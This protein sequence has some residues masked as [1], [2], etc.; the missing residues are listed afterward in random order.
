M[1][2]S[3]NA[4]RRRFRLPA[5][6]ATMLLCGMGI[7]AAHAA[8][9]TRQIPSAGVTTLNSAA[10]G[11]D[12]GLQF[13]EFQ[14]GL[15]NLNM[16]D[17]PT[18][19][20]NS[21]QLN[22][23]GG[24]QA[25]LQGGRAT[26]RSFARGQG[27]GEWVQGFEQ[28]REH[29]SLAL[30]FDGLNFRQ[31]RLAS[32]GN[33]F[34]VEPPDQ[35]LCVGNGFV[36]ETV[37]DV[38]RVFDTSGN[39][40]T[41]PIALNAFY[42]YAPAIDRT[43]HVFGPSIT[44]PSCYFD[45]QTQRWFHIVVTLDT[46]PASGGLLGSNHI[47]L[48]VSATPSPLGPWNIYRIPV[49]DDGTQ[50]TPVHA[51]CPCLGDYPH[52]GADA[53]GIY[54]TTNEF[55]LFVNGF[56]SAQ[57]YAISKKHLAQGAVSI[58]VVQIDTIDFLLEGNPGFTVWPAA[59]SAGEFEHDNRGTEYFV[60]SLA[61]FSNSNTDN[62]LRL[63]ALTNT[64]SLDSGS[65]NL[66]LANNTM[67][68]AS[69]GVPPPANQKP[70]STPLV[71]CINDT[72]LP[73]P[74]GPGCWHFLFANEP[75]HHE[76]MSPLDSN[77]SRIQQVVFADGKLY[78]ALDTVVTVAGN[79]QAGI[80]FYIIQPDLERGTI[81][82]KLKKQGNVALANNNVTYPAIAA[83]PNG[84][85]VMA[86]TLV[87]ADHHPS[88]AYVTVDEWFGAGPIHVAAEGA[89]P[90]DGFSDTIAYNLPNPP[91]PRWGDY[92]AAV[93]DGNSIW[94]ASEYINQ[95][96]TLAQYAAT[97]FGSCGGTRTALGNWSTRISRVTP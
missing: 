38:L 42:G 39:P 76:V 75:G 16:A 87:G 65:P 95:T 60:S 58:Q 26:N 68:V 37:N 57:I 79:D 21:M 52:I 67:N 83:L 29:P 69:Y 80:A 30:S 94:I 15:A 45:R 44:D 23:A 35:G 2:I 3:G 88:A 40:R 31:N 4:N 92:G 54:I 93:A 55:P 5:L 48:A 84:E 97:P 82:G 17:A 50:G 27:Y 33:Q 24:Q 19:S 11:I 56:N 22:I 51:N 77:D 41:S 91:R 7:A 96:C 12:G 89:G 13:P 86:F 49:Q 70:G 34:S 46:D 9:A 81:T 61:V 20:G 72:T 28:A 36:L 47:D 53:N 63:W 78:T 64:K 8:P 32:G 85:A 6:F 73:T 10:L 14:P 90:Q 66:F 25:V 74:A 18:S 1:K 59:S 43:A 62:R 71:D